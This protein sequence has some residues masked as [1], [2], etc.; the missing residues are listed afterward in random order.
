MP[1]LREKQMEQEVKGLCGICPAGCWVKIYRHGERI[2]KVET[3]PDQPL[4]TLCRIGRHSPDIV[5]DPDRLRHPMR[6][7]GSKG[8]YDFERI[9][10]DAAFEILVENLETIKQESGPEATAVY[11]GRGSFDMALC[12]L[13]QPADV[14]VSSASS[15]LFPFGS[16]NTLGVGALCYV[17]FAMIAPHV[18][19][20]EMLITMD[21]DIEQA[22]LII[23]WGANPATDSPPFSHQQ[24]MNA[25][26]RGAEVVV[27]DPRRSETARLT[28]AEWI[29][30]RPGTDGALAL[31]L[32]QVLLEEELFDHDFAEQ[33]T[34]GFPELER[35]VQHYRP[36]TVAGITGIEAETIR[37]LAR[38]I[39]AARG[40]APVMYSGL[41][42]SDSGVQAI[43]A[44]F[45]LWALAGQLDVPGGLLIRMKENVFPQNRQGLIPNPNTKLAL[46]RDRFPV[47]SMYRGESHAI[48]LPESV[49]EGDPYRIRSLIVLGGSIITSWPNPALWRR[50]LGALDFLTVIDRHLTADAA[51]ADLVLPATTLYE[52]TSYMRYGPVFKIRERVIPPVGEARSDFQILAELADRLGYGHLYPANE[53]ELLS[54]ALKGS[55]YTVDQV[56]EAGGSVKC[57]TAMMQY[58][59]WQKGLLRDDGKPGFATPSGKFEIASSILEEHGYD[60]LPVYTEP[61]EGPL[62]APE[63]TGD[64]PLVFNSGART[65]YDFRSQHHGVESLGANQPVPRVTI[66]TRDARSRGIEENDPVWVENQRG[67]VLF[68]AR[69][70][71]DITAGSVDANMGGGGPLGPEA[72]QQCNVNELTDHTHYDPISGFPIYKTLL[73]QVEKAA[74]VDFDQVYFS[75]SNIDEEDRQKIDLPVRQEAA[76]RVV[77]M[78]HNAT[79][80]VDPRVREA[81]L[82]FLTDGW[83]NPSSIYRLGSDVKM[84]LDAARRSIA[85]NLNCSARRIIFT[86]GGTEADNLAVMGAVNAWQKSNPDCKAHLITTAIEHPAV[87]KAC[88]ALQS[89]GH[90]LTVLDVDDTGLVDP[91]ELDAA[92][93]DETLLVSIMAANNEFGTIQPIAELAEVARQ[94]GVLFHTDAVQAFGKMELDVEDLG[95]DMLSVSSHKMHGPKGAGAL[96][97]REGVELSPLMTGGGQEGG[98]RSGTENVAG[99]IGFGKACDL[100][101]RSLKEG[102]EEN[103]RQLRDRLAAGLM[104]IFPDAR[105]NGH[106][107][108]RLANTLNMTLPGLRGESLVLAL[109]RKGIYFSSGSACKSGSPDPSAALLA[110][111]L[112]RDDAHC[113]VRFSLGRVNT[114]EDI[115]YVI[116][117]FGEVLAGMESAVRFVPC[118]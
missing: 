66:N 62:A 52:N 22:E 104:E 40:C 58:R 3:L 87:M 70:T 9:S 20:G 105:I 64:Y 84:S 75:V 19:M 10:W 33:W 24:I 107:E 41:E 44:V 55:G 72:W 94:H 86:S 59:K 95:V 118:R 97:V 8:N 81:M 36:E 73:C 5:H 79:T 112:S 39:A 77:Y 60:A 30:I 110:I 2:T 117:E 113:S 47:Y 21:T 108:Q 68:F 90:S 114:A 31:A 45:I 13:F 61:K 18:T 43:R 12:D 99:I 65:Y 106:P 91:H 116:G 82:P 29:P 51:Y 80:P 115:D 25:R 89:L 14:A 111:G 74:G 102:D 1:S 48:A 109:D 83:G 28:D 69:V 42:Y 7:K 15:I 71:D 67:K 88:L 49:L 63:L 6:R 85:H 92:I 32:I 53:E 27:I 50:T 46:G 35:M 11:T 54:Y 4:S 23:V 96:Y 101:M 93:R 98:L 103:I 16:P 38:R 76:R 26:R 57:R 100:A 56:R 17:S 34:I 37:Q 78:D